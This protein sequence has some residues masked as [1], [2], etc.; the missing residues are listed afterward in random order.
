MKVISYALFGYGEERKENCFV[1]HDY[2]RGLFINIRLQRML[3]PDWEI[4]LYTDHQTYEG[5]SHI[6]QDIE[7]KYVKILPQDRTHL[8]RAMLWRM[9]PCFDPDVERVICRDLDSPITYR[10]AQAVTFWYNKDKAAHAICDSVSHCIPMLGGMIGFKQRN[11]KDYTG[12]DTWESMVDGKGIDYSKKGADQDLLCKHVYPAFAQHGTD[13][14]TQH[15]FK[16]MPNTYLSDWHTCDCEP[17]VGHDNR[18]PNDIEIYRQAPASLK[19]TNALCGHIGASGY[20]TTEM[21][22][23]VHKYWEHFE[24]LVNIEKKHGDIFYWTQDV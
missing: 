12:F 1:F 6:F 20:Y 4:W 18:C 9:K 5:L 16:G 2:F 19:E 17:T 21:N 11:F 24:D 23:F 14:V 8:T 3:Y 15:Y 7:D 10:E 22:R 13:S